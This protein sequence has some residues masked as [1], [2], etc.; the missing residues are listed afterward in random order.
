MKGRHAIGV[1]A[2]L[3]FTLLTACDAPGPMWFWM[4]PESNFARILQD[5]FTQIV[6]LAVVVFVIVEGALLWAILR[7][8]AESSTRVPTQTHGNTR[9]EI[10]WT[11]A[12]TL[13][14]VAIAVPT[15]RTV[16]ETY[17]PPKVANPIRIVAVGH[18]WWWEFQYPDLNI[19]T[20]N[21]IVFPA[22]Q[23]VNL[24]IKSADVVHA[25]WIPKLGG[26]R[27]AI[28]MRT[29]VLWWTADQPGTYYGQCTQLCGTSHANMRLRAIV[30]TDAEWQAWLSAMG[31][32]TGVPPSRAP[33]NVQ[34]GYQ[35]VSTG[36]CIGCHA[37][38]GTSLVARAG[39][40]LT[41]FG[42]RITL[43]SGLYPNDEAHLIAWLRDPQGSK[44]GNK[45]PNLG[46]SDEDA[47]AI[48]AYLHSLK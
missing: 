11:I 30:K 34:R 14:L 12:P 36:A 40:D 2:T 41:R 6:V 16:F 22:G 38:K 31:S 23:Q 4:R 10:A 15:V 5:L 45:M 33:E 9:M 25:F 13:V 47:A 21:E 7:F 28:P 18:Q 32:A 29:N 20:A 39:P 44:P 19:I 3:L 46:L 24:E 1:A 42:D 26:K 35:L 27:D 43:G 37:I 48:A 17:N 8:R